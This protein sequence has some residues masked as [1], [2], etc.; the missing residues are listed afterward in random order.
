VWPFSNADSDLVWLS[1]AQY[2]ELDF[3]TRCQVGDPLNEGP[4]VCGC[5]VHGQKQVSQLNVRG[6]RWGPGI[7]AADCCNSAC[8]SSKLRPGC[9]VDPK[10]LEAHSN[11][12]L[13]KLT[14]FLDERHHAFDCLC[15][16]SK[17]TTKRSWHRHTRDRAIH[18]DDCRSFEHRVKA[19]IDLEPSPDCSATS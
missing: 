1:P 19:N 4:T 17:N 16:N 13:R 18:I 8:A 5:T 12:R 3:L 6:G 11:V 10:R 2:L 9:L 14:V 7:H 15:R